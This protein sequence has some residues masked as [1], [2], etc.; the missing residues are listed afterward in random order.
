MLIIW[1][2]FFIIMFFYYF[3]REFPTGVIAFLQGTLRTSDG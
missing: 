2:L 1:V 3:I